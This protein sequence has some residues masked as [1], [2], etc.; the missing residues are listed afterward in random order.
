M[1]GDYSDFLYF[2]VMGFNSLISQYKTLKK[3]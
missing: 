3:Y 1:Q 2:L